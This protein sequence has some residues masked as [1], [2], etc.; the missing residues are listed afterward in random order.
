M[1]EKFQALRW[2]NVTDLG[3]VSGASYVMADHDHYIFASFPLLWL[4]MKNREA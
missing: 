2:V 1:S 3:S 4:C